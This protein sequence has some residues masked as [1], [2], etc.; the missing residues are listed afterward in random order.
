ILKALIEKCPRDLPLFATYITSVLRQ[1]LRSSSIDMVESSI[2]T[3]ASFC[4]HQDPAALAADQEYIQ[5]Y[6]E[7]VRLYAA[8]ASKDS[9]VSVKPSPSVPVAI[10]F[11]KAG[12]EAIKSTAGSEALTVETARQ[13]YIVVPVVLQNIYSTTPNHL[14]QLQEKEQVH[15]QLE[16]DQ[17][18][19][20]RQ[21]VNTV[22]TRDEVTGEE[23]DPKAAAGTTADA[24]LLA[25]EEVGVLAIQC[26]RKIFAVNN[27]GQL[28]YATT[29]VLKFLAAR[30]TPGDHFSSNPPAHP[31]DASWPIAL[32][33]LVCTWAPV[34]DRYIILVT[35]METLIQSPIVE[36]DLEK[37][38]VLSAIISWLLG[39]NINLMGLSVMDVLIGLVQH[40]LLLLQLGGKGSELL[41]HPQQADAII[42]QDPTAKKPEGTKDVVMEI[43]KS[44]SST[45]IQLLGQLQKC[46][47]NLGTHVYYTDQIHDMLAA[48]L[49][50]LKSS[51][52][53][54]IPN[55]IA[56]V[57]DPV[58]TAESIAESV[59]MR[60]KPHTDGF[61]SFATARIVA[62]R[63]V[64]DILVV[65]NSKRQDGAAVGRSRVGESIWDGTQWLLRD[66]NPEVRRAY[67]E[68]L[69]TWLQFEVRK[70][71]Y[72]VVE[73]NVP[74]RDKRKENQ[75]GGN[76]A[77]RAV[78]NSSAVNR[79]S[80]RGVSGRSR[81]RPTFLPLLHLAAYDH[82]HQ[83]AASTEPTGEADFVI[84]HLLLSSLPQKLGVHAAR[85]GLPM[86]LRLQESIPSLSDPVAKV[87]VGSLVHGYLWALSETFEFESTPVGAE[88]HNE[89]LRRRQHQLWI[90]GVRV[91]PIP[92]DQIERITPG[93][94]RNK[95]DQ[96][97]PGL[98]RLPSEMVHTE[99]L[100]P[101]DHRTALVD[102][103]AKSYTTSLVPSPPSSPAASPGRSFSLPSL[104][105][106]PSY[107]QS[108]PDQLPRAVRD[109]FLADWS[110]EAC[111]E[112]VASANAK[113]VSLH[114]ST[115]LTRGRAGPLQQRLLAVNSM[116]AGTGT[117]APGSGVNT[118]Q[119][120]AASRSRRI[121]FTPTED[122]R[123]QLSSPRR[124]GSASTSDTGT[125]G[126]GEATVRIEDLK[127]VLTGQTSVPLTGYRSLL[128][129]AGRGGRGRSSGSDRRD[130]DT[131]SE[132]MVSY[133]GTDNGSYND[134]AARN[135]SAATESSALGLEEQQ[136]QRMDAVVGG[137]REGREGKNADADT[138][139]AVVERRMASPLRS[140]RGDGSNGA[141]KRDFSMLLEE[142][143]VG[144]AETRM[145]GRPP[146]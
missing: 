60:E 100:K 95:N 139:D 48:L 125:G 32:F 103:I 59:K 44:P 43:V 131:G 18:M 141:G 76:L 133:D 143:D 108:Q 49:M 6:E 2:P 20:R 68:A 7:I 87:R 36:N 140:E 57:A 112:G 89:I 126:G 58:G 56:A 40:V 65:A 26:L 9:V 30:I 17:A 136:Q 5:R 104:N 145:V 128:R 118:P 93:S 123:R 88:I 35:G 134:T 85:S 130:S 51:P 4:E 15:E 61:F 73:D 52:N 99:V 120:R 116:P 98:V 3:F 8:F 82:A 37:Q 135:L 11:R 121:G 78:S 86:V 42:S 81:S 50:R 21:S 55:A 83:Y 91:P 117:G 13:L 67:V 10:R 31:T 39:S 97:A 110:K 105:L 144:E 47:A 74:S 71:D 75:A 96:T 72:H 92:V 84:L 34:Q 54:T 138:E 23:A 129:E 111:I 80:S 1:I 119:R 63:S 33:Q 25:E 114:G 12:L 24:D 77:R 146:Y 16:K 101:F 132:S 90:E 109:E 19:K 64:K 45:R 14:R 66:P 113:S 107:Q 106:P 28:R 102:L 38:L 46:I 127:A 53:S 122:K 69:V 115:S 41:P 142:I 62:L 22:R 94:L 27:R 124:G 137:I 70:S 79:P 29:A